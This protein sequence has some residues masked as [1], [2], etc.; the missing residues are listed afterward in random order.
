M[1]REENIRKALKPYVPL[2]TENALTEQILKYRCHLTITRDRKTKAGDYRQPLGRKGH[3]ISVNG[4]LNKYAFLIT[5]IH[6]LAH[7]VCWEEHGNKVNPHGKEWKNTFTQTMQPFLREDVFPQDILPILKKHM[8]SPKSATVRDENL[9]R[10]LRNYDAPSDKLLL[11]SLALGADFLLGKK[12][13]V[14]GEKLRKRFRCEEKE[15]GRVYLVSGIAEV[16]PL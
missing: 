12:Q 8:E 1:N 3:R 16:Q 7:L 15:T 4:T 11:E 2:G 9:M 13:F 5:F 14:K 10:V 6:E